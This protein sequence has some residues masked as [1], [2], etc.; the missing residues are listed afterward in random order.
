MLK[1]NEYKKCKT[2]A[3]IAAV[4]SNLKR[5]G[6]DVYEINKLASARRRELIMKEQQHIG[7]DVQYLKASDIPKNPYTCISL[8]N[9]E[10][11]ASPRVI[12]H[13]DKSVTV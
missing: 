6:E 5:R 7:L 3:D 8:R 1:G 10:N 2:T 9:T 13:A 11:P 4:S 12:I